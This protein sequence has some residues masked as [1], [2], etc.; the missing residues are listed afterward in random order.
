MIL[1]V[2]IINNI[3]LNKYEQRPLNTLSPEHYGQYFANTFLIGYPLHCLYIEFNISEYIFLKKSIY[4]DSHF[5][6]N[7]F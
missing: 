2:M 4:F 1:H 6:E 3:S 7:M 5:N